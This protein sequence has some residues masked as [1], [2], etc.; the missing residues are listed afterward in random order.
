MNNKKISIPVVLALAGALLMLLTIFLPYIAVTEE[1]EDTVEVYQELFD[2]DMDEG[3]YKSISMTKIPGLLNESEDGVGTIYS[4]IVIL[5]AGF[6]ALAALCAF[7]KKPIL[8]IICGIISA[9]VF[10]VQNTIYTASEIVPSDYLKWGIAYYV[11]YIAAIL[12]LVGAIAIM[13]SKRAA[14]K[15]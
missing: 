15:Q 6:A 3:D 9:V 13:V 10:T 5:V 8:T 4:V 11:F 1:V 12:L 2:V 7:F 14:K